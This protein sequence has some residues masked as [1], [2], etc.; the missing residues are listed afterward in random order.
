M[1]VEDKKISYLKKYTE[2]ARSEFP[3]ASDEEILK[4]VKLF[5]ETTMEKIKESV[6]NGKA[7]VKLTI[8]VEY[9]QFCKSRKFEFQINFDATK[10]KI[11]EII[12]IC[13]DWKNSHYRSDNSSELFTDEC[14]T[15]Y[16]SEFWMTDEILTFKKNYVNEN[17]E[18]PYTFLY[19]AKKSPNYEFFYHDKSIQSYIG[20]WHDITTIII[21]E[22]FEHDGMIIDP[23][24]RGKCWI[25]V[26][27]YQL[28]K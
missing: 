5:H 15:Y 3:Y 9:H 4:I 18:T 22:P 24:N 27:D 28:I 10:I 11:I 2:L 17:C 20:E 1:G 12:E 14:G 8:S 16:I 25:T 7:F 23:V 6:G 13:N 21:A 19:F 26:R